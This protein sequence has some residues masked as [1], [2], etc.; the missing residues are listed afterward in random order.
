MSILFLFCLI[1]KEFEKGCYLIL[2]QT[3]R[4]FWAKLAFIRP[5]GK[6]KTVLHIIITHTH[7]HTH[8]HTTIKKKELVCV[9]YYFL[10]TIVTCFG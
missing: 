3:V 5:A 7:T 1:E 2:V 8:T 6:Q 9:F 10:L 4:T